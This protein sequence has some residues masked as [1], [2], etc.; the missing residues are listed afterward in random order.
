[1]YWKY[2]LSKKSLL[3]LLFNDINTWVPKLLQAEASPY[4]YKPTREELFVRYLE[5]ILNSI[6]DEEFSSSLQNSNDHRFEKAQTYWD[7]LINTKKDQVEMLMNC[8]V[9]KSDSLRK[10]KGEV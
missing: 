8:P 5:V 6:V 7:N 10:K 4:F 1:M 9:V 3:I 2:L